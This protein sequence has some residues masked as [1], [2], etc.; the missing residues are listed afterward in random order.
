MSL[1]LRLALAGLACAV[2][3]GTSAHAQDVAKGQAVF[4]ANC[5]GCHTL[6]K[7]GDNAAGLSLFGVVGRK[8]GAAPGFSYSSAIQSSGV[9]WTP[10]KLDAFIAAPNSVVVGSN[11][12]FGGLADAGD[13]ANL[14]AYLK[15]LK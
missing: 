11:M 2:A 4:A 3:A 9:V 13:R 8:A 1:P 5:A 14:I 15:T 12:Y 10:A 6:D 7:S